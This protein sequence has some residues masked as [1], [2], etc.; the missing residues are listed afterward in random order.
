MHY[1]PILFSLLRVM[2]EMGRR[3]TTRI[4]VITDT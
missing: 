1:L 3:M 2:S 4:A